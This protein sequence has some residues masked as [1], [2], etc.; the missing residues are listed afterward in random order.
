MK[1]VEER[2]ERYIGGLLAEH[3]EPVLLA[4]EAEAAKEGFPI[5]GRHVGVTLTLLAESI[6]ASRIFELG[7]G[8][9]FSAYWFAR[10]S[11]TLEVHCTDGDPANEQ[12]AERYLTD[13]GLWDR[14]TYHVGDAVTSLNAT[15]GLYDIV[16]NDIDKDGYPD[17]WAAARNR[18]R[19]GGFY[20]CDNVLWSGRVAEPD[21]ADERPEWTSA[22]VRHN[23]MV[24]SDPDWLATILP[25]R[26]GVILARR[27]R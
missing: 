11:T 8:Y 24:F 22:I 2:V 6:G 9:G 25:I 1:I 18:V 5:V 7:S 20:I 19:V 17:A 10:A 14:I 16:Y 21:P 27:R 15:D 12:K 13:A 26:D 3:D 23:E 4:M